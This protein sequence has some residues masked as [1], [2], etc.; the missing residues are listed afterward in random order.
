M[1]K[2]LF[3]C[4][5]MLALAACQKVPAG[6]V[7][8]KV[9]LYGSDKG[10]NAEEVGPGR[11]WLGFNEELY[12]FPTFSQ[13]YT[14]QANADGS[15]GESISFQDRDGLVASAD[16]GIT[17]SIDPSKAT[18]IFQ[19]YRKGIDEITDTYLRNMVR[20]AL[21]KRAGSQALDYLY[22]AGKAQLI[23]D[24][25]KDVVAQV[26]PIGIRIE[27]I[28][29][30]G[31]IRLPP[32]VQARITEKNVVA[33]KTLQ[34]K[35][36]V[37]QAN[38]EAAKLV[39]ETQGQAQKLKIEREAEAHA[40]LVK[41]KAEAEGK[42][43]LAEAEAKGIELRAKAEAEG[44]KARS[45]AITDNLI[46]YEAAKTW[47]GEVPKVLSGQNTFQYMDLLKAAE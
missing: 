30:V 15:L 28:Y 10:V 32:E 21:V 9:Y 4:V 35:A 43:A 37:E 24:V 38:A 40:N 33:Q 25:Q 6:N 23:E 5:S 13:T 41:A 12:L 29:W 27:K 14:W 7:G 18:E 1:K 22:G 16:I 45:E 8:V 2:I 34:R 17:Y 3:V 44:I 31:A 42:L 46:R 36:E 20:D 26:E 39:A 47:K 11:Y 19:K